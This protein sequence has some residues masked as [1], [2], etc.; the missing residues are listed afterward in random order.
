M[1]FTDTFVLD[2]SELLTM[3][4]RKF[5]HDG[6]AAGGFLCVFHSWDLYLIQRR[7]KQKLSRTQDG[8]NS[9]DSKRGTVGDSAYLS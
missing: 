9:V 4:Y 8:N 5:S 2:P 1:Q 7:M 6:L 3:G